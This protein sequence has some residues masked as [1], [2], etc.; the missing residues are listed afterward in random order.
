MVSRFKLILTVVLNFYSNAQNNKENATLKY[1]SLKKNAQKITVFWCKTDPDI[2]LYM[3]FKYTR[4][5]QK[6][7]QRDDNITKRQFEQPLWVYCTWCM[8]IGNL[9]LVNHVCTCVPLYISWFSWHQFTTFHEGCY[10]LVIMLYI[11]T[12]GYIRCF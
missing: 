4:P 2:L 5:I 12:V 1:E 9:F 3:E 7:F 10:F 8:H 6:D 11:L